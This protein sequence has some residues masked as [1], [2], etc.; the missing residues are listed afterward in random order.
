MSAALSNGY[1]VSRQVVA[2]WVKT[3]ASEG[4]V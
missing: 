3:V 1:S 4:E 2:L